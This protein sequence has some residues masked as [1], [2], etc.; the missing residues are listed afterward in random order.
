MC[1][2]RKHLPLL[3]DLAANL[4]LPWLAYTLTVEGH[5]E[6]YALVASSIPPLIWS[7]V[8]LCWH[9]RLDA[10]SA[11]VLAG[12]ALS[13]LAMFCG[14]DARLLLVRES[15]VSGLI[16]VIFLI[17]L[18]FPQP[19][20]F[21][22]ARA[23]IIRQN[24]GFGAERFRIWWQDARS[25]RT[26]RIVTA[27]WGIGLT[28]EALLRT[29]LAWHWQPQRFLAIAPI[30]GY[31]IAGVICVWTFWFLRGRFQAVA[32]RSIPGAR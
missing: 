32:N 27:V 11:F 7:I 22:L 16:G 3:A 20:V 19:V 8:E 14:G 23:T 26:I 4:F 1:R 17:S 28:G 25:R 5:G 9:R 31:C 13:I 2:M 18:F 30:L 21:Y 15:L 24:S 12:I 29:W 10:L 6:F